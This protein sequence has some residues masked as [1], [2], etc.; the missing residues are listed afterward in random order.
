MAP[1]WSTAALT[2]S[3]R[4]SGPHEEV[5]ELDA[6]LGEVVYG[7][8]LR[9]HGQLVALALEWTTLLPCMVLGH[10]VREA[11]AHDV[12]EP[13]LDVPRRASAPLGADDRPDEHAGVGDADREGAEGADVHEAELGVL[14]EDR[15]LRA[16]LQ[17]AERLEADESTLA[18]GKGASW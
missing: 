2:A 11:G 16:P 3:G 5:V 4:R 12:L 18:L 13:A 15:L 1:R 7:A 9:G 6:V 8:G 17:L 10:D 14:E